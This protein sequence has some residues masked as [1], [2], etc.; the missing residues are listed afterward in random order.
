MEKYRYW[1]HFLILS[2]SI[3]LIL[4]SRQRV[5]SAAD[6]EAEPKR[7]AP[8]VVSYT[9]STWWLIRWEDNEILCTVTSNQENLPTGDEIYASCGKSVY[10]IW[11]QT[12]PCNQEANQCTGV[13]LHLVSQE[14]A[15]RTVL[16]EY[17]P[18]EIY[19]DL[20]NCPNFA[21]DHLC[22]RIPSLVFT[23]KEPIPGE[24]I[25]AIHGFIAGKPF[26]CQGE[27]CEVPLLPT[28]ATGV[29]ITFIAESSFGDTSEEFYAL[30][31]IVESGVSADPSRK[32]WYVDILSSQWNGAPVQVCAQIWDAFPPLVETPDWLTTPAVP[33]L[34]ATE[35][36]YYYLAGR[37]IAQGLV[38]ADPC[39]GSGLQVNGYADECGLQ[40]ALPQVIEWQNKFDA[41]ILEVANRVNIPAQLLKNIFAQE[42]QFWPGAFKDPN[43]FGLGQ[44][45]DNGAETILLWDTRFFHQFC[46]EVF[47]NDTCRRGYVFLNEDHQKILRGALVNQVRADCPGCTGGL[48][49]DNVED[50]IHLFAHTLVAN[51]AQ[52][53]RIFY[54]ATG[55]RPGRVS[56]YESL[57]LAT[58]ANYH[59]GPG[60]LSYAVHTAWSNRGLIEGLRE[61]LDWEFISFYLTP[62]CKSAEGYINNLTK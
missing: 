10:D 28:P 42:S 57:W 33:E 48:N 60:C 34:L 24:T 37:L 27:S 4:S 50:S 52:V 8:I 15:E 62:A 41:Q 9:R 47:D 1:Q 31:R 18:P 36:P 43:E 7:Q 49:L 40:A 17:P 45:T 29:E 23:G 25:T 14:P 3:L 32:G 16:I 26:S 20:N 5:A 35:K 19:L 11:A 58:A 55:N 59:V 13:Y 2:F 22:S 53:S 39:A 51:C 38:N 54:N 21:A 44:M 12:P 61:P 30:A 56:D 46:P 6:G